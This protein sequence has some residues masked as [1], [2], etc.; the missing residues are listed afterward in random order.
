MFARTS[1]KRGRTRRQVLDILMDTEGIE[2]L[3]DCIG[4]YLYFQEH[5]TQ[6][7]TGNAR[8]SAAL[9]SPHRQLIWYHKTVAIAP[10][11]STLEYAEAKKHYQNAVFVRADPKFY[12][13]PW[14]SDVEIKGDEN[15]KWF[16]RLLLVIR[17][18]TCTHVHTLAWQC[19][20]Q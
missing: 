19:A 20:S 7:P 13:K 8:R 6:P 9:P 2:H 14:F 18:A 11:A 1:K 15:E 16:A 12:S 3:R 17:Y 4:S 5:G 10:G